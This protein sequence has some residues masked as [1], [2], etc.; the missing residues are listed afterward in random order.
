MQDF[1]NQCINR[2]KTLDCNQHFFKKKIYIFLIWLDY[3]IPH[4]FN[5]VEKF[6]THYFPLCE[7]KYI[8]EKKS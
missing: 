2:E 7:L 4:L 6:Y 3:H 1:I 5:I 8:L